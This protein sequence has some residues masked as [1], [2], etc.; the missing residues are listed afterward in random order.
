MTPGDESGGGTRPATDAV[1]A[2]RRSR[3]GAAMTLHTRVRRRFL[4]DVGML[5]LGVA[6]AGLYD[7][8][9]QLDGL[10]WAVLFTVLTS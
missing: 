5:A 4:V 3:L 7:G 1:G 9:P 2:E 10:P 6:V 8:S